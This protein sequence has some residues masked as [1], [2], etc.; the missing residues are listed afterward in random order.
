MFQTRSLTGESR[1]CKGRTGK[2]LGQSPRGP[3]SAVFDLHAPV[4]QLG[5]QSVGLLEVLGF[6]GFVA[7]RDAGFDPALELGVRGLAGGED[8]QHAHGV[9]QRCQ[10]PLGPPSLPSPP[11]APVPLQPP[12]PTPGEIENRSRTAAASTPCAR[13]SRAVRKFP[14]RFDILV[15]RTFRNSPCSQ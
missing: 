2:N 12:N 8:V 6:P 3:S 7:R 14:K 4:A 11:P 5:T 10:C 9:V 15:P 1:S 13:R